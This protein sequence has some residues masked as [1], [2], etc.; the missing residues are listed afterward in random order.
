MGYDISMRRYKKAQTAELSFYIKKFELFPPPNPKKIKKEIQPHQQKFME[1]F[2]IFPQNLKG[3]NVLEIGPELRGTAFIDAWLLDNK[4]IKNIVGIDP[5]MFLHP[6]NIK[7]KN[8]HYILGIGEYLPFRSESFDL[9]IC[10]NVLDHMFSPSKALEEMYRCLKNQGILLISVNCFKSIFKPLF[11]LF[12][13][14]DRPHPHHFTKDDF[15][16]LIRKHGFKI[17]KVYEEPRKVDVRKIKTLKR[18]IARYLGLKHV[19]ILCK[20][21]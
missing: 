9:I 16:E 17:K 21:E 7:Q 1:K 2:G 4:L 19:V 13:L 3:K 12:S 10:V 6:R 5:L 15:I 20:K 18:Y 8:K 11:P 14:I